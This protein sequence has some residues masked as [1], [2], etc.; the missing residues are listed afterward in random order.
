MAGYGRVYGPGQETWPATSRNDR[1]LRKSRRVKRSIE[2]SCCGLEDE[3]VELEVSWRW[4][5][6][7]MVT[8]VVVV[9]QML[10]RRQRT[11]LPEPTLTLEKSLGA[12]WYY[13]A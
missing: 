3:D 10:V 11:G 4:A 12:A 1:R 9:T 5:E 8:R 13:E 6:V 7:E 2:S